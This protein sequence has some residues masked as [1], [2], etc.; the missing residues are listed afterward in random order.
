M[1]T[2][3]LSS[4][5]ISSSEDETKEFARNLAISLGPNSIIALLGDLGSGKT[6]FTKGLTEKLQIENSDVVTSPTFTYLNIYEAPIPIYHFDLY[7]IET[8]DAFLAMGFEE[9]FYNKGIC[10]IEW[11]DPILTILPKGT[12]LIRISH[13]DENQRKI[14]INTL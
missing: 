3:A 5:F 8:A 13:I 10:L 9:Y 1:V 12:I 7:R 6:T 2:T 4:E 11:A 14:T